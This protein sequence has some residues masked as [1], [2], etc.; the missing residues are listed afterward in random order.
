MVSK[1]LW[2][3]SQAIIL[4]LL[5]LVRQVVVQGEADTS[6]ARRE[7]KDVRRGP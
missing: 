2:V 3:G 6:G 1:H 7:D 4:L 5:T